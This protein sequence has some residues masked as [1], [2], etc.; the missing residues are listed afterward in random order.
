MSSVPHFDASDSDRIDSAILHVE[1]DELVQRAF[2]QTVGKLADI[3]A[4]GDVKG[5]FE[6]LPMRR[7]LAFF[8]DLRLPDG[9]GW[10]VL[11]HVRETHPLV[12]AL[13]F[14]SCLSE[15][16][17]NRAH[18]EGAIYVLKSAPRDV[19]RKL[20][21]DAC[22]TQCDVGHQVHVLMS[23]ASVRFG[24]SETEAVFM[25]SEICGL[26][27]GEYI[28]GTHVGKWAIKDHVR[29]ILGKVRDRGLRV[30]DFDDLRRYFWRHLT[31]QPERSVSGTGFKAQRPR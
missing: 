29:N 27:R 13:L 23:Q 28:N 30:A 10:D 25:E 22:T 8:I 20:A 15:E 19:V 1:D 3:T 16:V 6:V 26:P 11:A 12:P 18:R 5:A 14:T 17:S 24:L 31:G 9:T 2:R 4:V 21:R 7:W